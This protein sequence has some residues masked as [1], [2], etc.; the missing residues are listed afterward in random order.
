MDLDP[1]VFGDVE[2]V[3]GH[4]TNDVALVPPTPGSKIPCW[5][6]VWR[7]KGSLIIVSIVFVPTYYCFDKLDHAMNCTFK[8]L[9]NCSR[10]C[11]NKDT[12]PPGDPKHFINITEFSPVHQIGLK[13]AFK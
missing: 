9:P 6:I 12:T 7:G 13:L 11:T 3:A 5:Q 2:E 1:L 10:N 8:L 4:K